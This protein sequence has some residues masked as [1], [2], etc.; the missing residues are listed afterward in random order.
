VNNPPLLLA[1]EPTGNLDSRS[2]GEI[3]EILTG[4]NKQGTTII[5]VTHD[6]NVADRCKRIVTVMDGRITDDQ[7]RK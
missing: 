3:L 4:L 2:G 1:D 7:V 5:I 6:R